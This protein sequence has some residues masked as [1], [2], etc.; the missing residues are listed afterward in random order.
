[1]TSSACDIEGITGAD[2]CLG[3]LWWNQ[4]LNPIIGDAGFSSI[5][6]RK[7]RESDRESDRI[8]AHLVYVAECLRSQPP[9]AIGPEARA[10]RSACL[11]SLEEYALAG[12]FPKHSAQP[13]ARRPIFVD[14]R[15]TPCAVAHLMVS[16][17]AEE[18]CRTIDSAHHNSLI[19]DLLVEA[20]PALVQ[21]I[22]GWC[23]EMGLEPSELS[24]IQPGYTDA[25]MRTWSILIGT[26]TLGAA[27]TFVMGVGGIVSVMLDKEG[28]SIASMLLAASG[29]IQCFLL[30][31]ISLVVIVCKTKS[32]WAAAIATFAYVV[33]C[34][35]SAILFSIV[36]LES[37]A[38]FALASA[39][40]I[41]GALLLVY[42]SYIIYQCCCASWSRHMP[43]RRREIPSRDLED[44]DLVTSSPLKSDA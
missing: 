18:L 36:S 23:V 40:G 10:K 1:M 5:Y 17:G 28:A 11:A 26:L 21:R 29:I 32:D 22:L 37:R 42:A 31:V 2:S 33:S 34:M 39:Q 4:P 14:S 3:T 24:M 15:G 44:G 43:V 35:G 13:R 30:I 19:E 6:D 25:H 7:P 8:R 16:S 38:D 41:L 27:G 12:R 9:H 20:E